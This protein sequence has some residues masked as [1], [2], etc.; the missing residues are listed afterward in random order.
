MRTIC[1]ISGETSG[2][3]VLLLQRSVLGRVDFQRHAISAISP[4]TFPH[5][6][7]NLSTCKNLLRRRFRFPL[8]F[9]SLMK[10]SGCL[11]VWENLAVGVYGLGLV[12]DS[13]SLIIAT[14][15]LHF[16][17]RRFAH[18]AMVFLKERFYEIIL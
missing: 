12:P 16:G 4:E 14:C 15:V 17:M 5:P 10:Y 1:L 7:A 8:T 11:G 2:P 9:H 6:R 13:S 18:D 3:L